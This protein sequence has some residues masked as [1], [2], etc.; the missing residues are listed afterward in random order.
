MLKGIKKLQ[1]T[2]LNSTYGSELPVVV[3][4]FPHSN[5]TVDE[6]TL[7]VNVRGDVQWSVGRTVFLLDSVIGIK[8]ATTGEYPSGAVY[9]FIAECLEV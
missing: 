9:I 5:T 6:G 3:S 4:I 8:A 1:S 2:I 7:E